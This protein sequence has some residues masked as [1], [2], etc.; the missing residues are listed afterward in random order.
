MLRHINQSQ[1]L[2]DLYQTSERYVGREGGAI[3]EVHLF[4]LYFLNQLNFVLNIFV[5]VWV[6]T[7]VRWGLKVIVTE[8]KSACYT[9]NY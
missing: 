3:G 7:T 8:Q 4:L 5:C 2:P 6:M 9:S 1:K